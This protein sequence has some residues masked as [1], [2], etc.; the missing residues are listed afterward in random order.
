[1]NRNGFKRSEFGFDTNKTNPFTFISIHFR[2]LGNIFNSYIFNFFLKR[3]LFLR[4]F[5]F[6]QL[7]LRILFKLKT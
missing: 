5:I 1:L 6:M 2:L 7:S 3:D 4:V